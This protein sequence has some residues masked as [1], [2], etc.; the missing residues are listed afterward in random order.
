V[1]LKHGGLVRALA[2]LK[3]GRLPS[4]SDDVTIKLWPKKRTDEPVVIS[5]GSRLYA[6]A[7]LPDG[8]LASAGQDGKIKLWLVDEKKLIA[9]LCLRAGCNLTREEWARYIGSDTPP[10]AELSRPSFKLAN[11]RTPTP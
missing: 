11:W 9:H 1:V 5:H 10:A 2:V 6:L 4:G 8:R 7:G 3:D